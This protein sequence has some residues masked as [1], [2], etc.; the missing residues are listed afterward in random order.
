[1]PRYRLKS[2]SIDLP[3]FRK[4]KT[5]NL[6]FADRITL[7]AG[8]N[9]IGKS[10]ILALVA[11][12]SG[13]TDKTFET[14]TGRT[15]QGNLNEIIYIDY[16]LEFE[17]IKKTDL[18]RPILTYDLEGHQFQK[19]CALTK[20]TRPATKRT[21]SRLEVR[22]VP[23]NITSSE[24]EY[25][26][27]E[28][29]NDQSSGYIIPGTDTV[30]GDSAKVPIPTI[31]LGMTRMLPIGE[32]D[33]DLIEN[34][35]DSE[36]HPEDAE[37]IVSF[38]NKVIGATAVKDQS[39]IVTQGIRGT[40]K[41]SKH[42]TYNH[43]AKTVSLGQDSLSSI[44][45]AL[46]SFQK[47]FREWGEN[48]PGGILVIDEIDA[49]FHPHA[50][51]KLVS[52]ISTA[53]REL[54]LQVIATTHS[55]PMIESVHPDH[56][57]EKSRDNLRDK[58]IYITDTINPRI[59]DLSISEIRDDMDLVA[60]KKP[61]KEPRKHLKL[62]LED[63]EA[64]LFFKKLLTRKLR[65]RIR[66]ECDF[67]IQPIPI[68]IG[69]DNLQGLQNF[70]SHFKKVIIIVDADATVRK[71]KKNI[72]KLPGGRG[73]DGK[74]YNP[75]RTLYEFAKTLNSDAESHAAT[76][77]ALAKMNVT[78]DH[79][80]ECLLEGDFDITKRKSAE[81]WLKNRISYIDDWGLIELW[82]SENPAAVKEF[83]DS[84]VKAACFIAPLNR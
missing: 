55:L 36:I 62:Y 81:N 25:T 83:E 38:V 69:C 29:I 43:S 33:P 7:I 52:L 31:Y 34:S 44:A 21:P 41:R 74:G 42:P 15:F 73:A 82:F 12:G 14:Y 22:V 66:K 16:E 71:D 64:N 77:Q 80:H 8:H 58:V 48:Y 5:I 46:A 56:K 6:E 60:P 79:V 70:D 30:I 72:V 19:R 13:L 20:R 9:G 57:P 11:N 40:T 1:M 53:A 35:P 26:N 37:F 17:G 24:D 78:S 67:N 39:G 50:Q 59:S 2:L 68:S 47:I 61:A 51:K 84:L 4:L 27:D 45:T 18:P 10:T 32:I 63:A 49:G 76:W 28:P 65:A 3:A 54:N 23:R 75:E